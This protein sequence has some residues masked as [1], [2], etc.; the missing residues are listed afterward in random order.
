MFTIKI[1]S[2]K[3]GVNQHR[4]L[5]M[6]APLEGPLLMLFVNGIDIPDVVK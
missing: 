1:S 4:K 5:C 3:K 6:D 2:L